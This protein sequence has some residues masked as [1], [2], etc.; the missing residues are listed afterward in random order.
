MLGLITGKARNRR[1]HF[2]VGRSESSS[3]V[4][5]SVGCFPF[6]RSQE[7]LETRIIPKRIEHW[8]EPKLHCSVIAPKIEMSSAQWN[9]WLFRVV[10]NGRV[11][12]H[13]QKNSGNIYGNDYSAL[14]CL[15]AT[16]TRE[17]NAEFTA[18]ANF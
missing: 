10:V 2:P 14:N 9:Y 6:G 12:P 11:V 13:N 1:P 18:G 4:G 8:I 15:R 16:N 3:A 17:D 7:F 5:S